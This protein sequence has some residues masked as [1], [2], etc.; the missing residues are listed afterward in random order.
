LWISGKE[1]ACNAGD[2][3]SVPGSGRSPGDGN[4]YP[5]QYSCLDNPMDRETWKAI[6]HGVAEIQTQLST[7]TGEKNKL[8][9]KNVKR[10]L[11]QT[12]A[13]EIGR[14]PQS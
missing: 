12:K 4:G 9:C 3:G 13:A 2:P 5:L 10:I 1:S 7:T 8:R 11:L 6:I 14:Q